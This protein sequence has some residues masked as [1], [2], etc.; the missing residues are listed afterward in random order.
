M[1]KDKLSDIFK[2]ITEDLIKAERSY[3]CIQKLKDSTIHK[4]QETHVLH[5]FS[6]IYSLLLNEFILSM[7]RIFEPYKKGNDT[8][9]FNRI[10]N[11]LKSSTDSFPLFNY[12][13]M[14]INELNMRNLNFGD[15]SEKDFKKYLCLFIEQDLIQYHDTVKKI[16]TWKDKSLSH[17]DTI[18]KVP[19]ISYVDLFELLNYAWNLIAVLQWSLTNT[20]IKHEQTEFLRNDIKRNTNWWIKFVEYFS[21]N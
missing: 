21:E 12:K 7:G 18:G 10:L 5:S 1:N 17:N 8:R 16:K 11:E 14:V 6:Y 3:I 20:I 4:T 19:D 15:G 9:C 2:G 13:E